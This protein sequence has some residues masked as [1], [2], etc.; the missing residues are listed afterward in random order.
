M[1]K[2]IIYFFLIAITVSSCEND[3][4]AVM[5]FDSKKAAVENGSDIVA[6][7]SQ[8]GKVSAKLLAPS[9]ERSLDKPT[10]VEFKKGLKLLMYDTTLQVTSTLTAKH[11]K[12]LEEEGYV[13]L[14][15]SVVLVTAKGE[16]LNTNELN[17]DPK[18]KIFYSTKEVFINTPTS[19]LHGWGLEANE[20]FSVKKIISVSGPITIED[21]TSMSQDAAPGDSL[22][23]ASAPAPATIQP[24]GVPAGVSDSAHPATSPANPTTPPASPSPAP[25]KPVVNVP[26]RLQP[27]PVATPAG[28]QQQNGVRLLEKPKHPH[29]KPVRS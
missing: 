8:N 19:Q 16:T 4:Q 28:Q 22:A 23:P 1:I 17:Y 2:R 3:I 20:D 7:F 21:S 11:G 13:Y 9:M 18:R 25:P 6:M 12:Y 10:Y 15:D 29:I 27:S 26:A 14:R 24:A 5:E